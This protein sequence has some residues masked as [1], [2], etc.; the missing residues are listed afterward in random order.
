[1]CAGCIVYVATVVVEAVGND[2]VGHSKS[3]IVTYNLIKDVLRDGHMGGFVLNKHLRIALR[4]VHHS[5]AT[6]RHI[7]EGE[8]NFVSYATGRIAK[9]PHKESDKMLTYPLL[10]R[11]HNVSATYTI[12]NGNISIG[13]ATQAI[14]VGGQIQ[15]NHLYRK[16]CVLV[17]LCVI[18]PKI[19]SNIGFVQIMR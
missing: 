19:T 11:E 10:G 5:V 17:I 15:L 9:M 4:I 16:T 8:R 6:A 1:M 7:V 2:D 14:G 13:I 3:G 12:P 18:L